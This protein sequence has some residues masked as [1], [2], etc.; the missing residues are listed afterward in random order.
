MEEAKER[1]EQM[2][3]E[4]QAKIQALKKKAEKTQGEIKSALEARVARIQQDYEASQAKV[5]HLLA[6]QLKA[7]AASLEA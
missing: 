6:E 2:R 5:K 4:T 7:K 1:S 3:L